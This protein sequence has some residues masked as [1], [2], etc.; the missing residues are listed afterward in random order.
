MKSGVNYINLDTP[1]IG[2]VLPGVPMDRGLQNSES[3]GESDRAANP[4]KNRQHFGSCHPDFRQW[5]NG[6]LA[7]TVLSYVLPW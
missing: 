7:N 2:S 3:T 5:D 6:A 4:T 1:I